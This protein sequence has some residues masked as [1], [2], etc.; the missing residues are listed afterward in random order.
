MCCGGAVSQREGGSHLSCEAVKGLMV[1]ARFCSGLSELTSC[2][3][4]GG[5]QGF[6]SEGREVR[7]TFSEFVT[8]SV[9]SYPAVYRM[10]TFSSFA[11]CLCES[12]RCRERHMNLF[13]CGPVLSAV[14]P[15]SQVFQDGGDRAWMIWHEIGTARIRQHFS[16]TS[17]KMANCL[18]TSPMTRRKYSG[19]PPGEALHGFPGPVGGVLLIHVLP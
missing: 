4:L 13:S 19:T 11:R 3:C 17:R 18:S 6:V 10:A 14:W 1:F 15:Y 2:G 5:S 7:E 9:Y 12:V 16:G 8:V